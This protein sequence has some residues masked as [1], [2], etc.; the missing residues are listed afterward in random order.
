M[1]SKKTLV[2]TLTWLLFVAYLVTC[3]YGARAKP[4][5]PIAYPQGEYFA[6][7]HPLFTKYCIAEF[8]NCVSLISKGVVA[9]CLIS[10]S[11][12]SL[13]QKYAVGRTAARLVDQFLEIYLDSPSICLS[14]RTSS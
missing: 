14:T 3:S 12:S 4:S 10:P 6:F 5:E 7:F 11:H 13:V 1:L 9:A 8:M 2:I